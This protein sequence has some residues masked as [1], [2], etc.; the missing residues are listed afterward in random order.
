MMLVSLPPIELFVDVIAV[1]SLHIAFVLAC[2]DCQL[3]RDRRLLPVVTTTS[4]LA[5]LWMYR[6][7]A[8]SGI[9]PGLGVRTTVSSSAWTLL[10]VNLVA[11]SL[12][13]ASLL[14]RSGRIQSYRL[15]GR[16]IVFGILVGLAGALAARVAML[17]PSA[18][19]AGWVAVPAAMGGLAL[20]PVGLA[21]VLLLLGH[22]GDARVLWSTL[23]G[24]GLTGASAAIFLVN[25][26]PETP[27]WT[28][29]EVLSLL[30]AV[31]LLAG[32]LGLYPQSVRA[33]QLVQQERVVLLRQALEASESERRRIARDL[34]D[35]AVQDLAAV[36][37][38]LA[39]TS[40]RLSGEGQDDL[41]SLLD[42]AAATTR[43]TMAGLR[44]LIVDIY[45]PN[46]HKEGIET[47]LAD[48]CATARSRGLKVDFE[49]TPGLSMSEQAAATTY[50]I[51]QE[52][53]R[54]ALRHA[55]ATALAVS[56]VQDSGMVQLEVA[57]DGR[58]F[59]RTHESGA[60]HLG[61]R[62][63]SD[64]AREVGGRLEIRSRPGQ[65]AVVRLE[66][67]S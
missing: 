59:D 45:P 67:I 62:L 34:H 30:V 1:L 60:G 20:L 16:A 9:V 15:I 28:L 57:D 42:Q 64:L 44:S 47:A 8:S 53:V 2:L 14:H 54:N 29:A 36:S 27:L 5:A 37:F 31:A 46:L 25:P 13:A 4:A 41:A 6:L 32:M 10:L 21:C 52:A 49:V 39:G 24:L 22:R 18:E 38:S 48:L 51:A 40:R 35:S 11:S 23:F 3:R 58:G 50:R 63:L 33:E 17:L 7:F 26:H 61:L 12:L 66:M 55:R 43:E 56:L 19:I 65:G